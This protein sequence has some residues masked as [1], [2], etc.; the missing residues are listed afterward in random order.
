LETEAMTDIHRE[1]QTTETMCVRPHPA[2]LD[3]ISLA[4]TLARAIADGVFGTSD[5]AV[6][7]Y[8]LSR[9]DDVLRSLDVA[10][11]PNTLHAVAVKANP[12][13]EVLKRLRTAGHGAEVASIGEIELALAAGFPVD[14]IVFD[15][16]V[17]TL[18]ELDTALTLGLRVN[19]NSLSELARIESLYLPLASRSIVGVRINPEVGSGSIAAT[20]VAVPYSKFGVSLRERREALMRA[21]SEYRWLQA[22]HVHIGSQGMSLPQLLDGVGSV[23]EFFLDLSQREGIHRFNIGGGLPAKYRDSDAPPAFDEYALALRQRCPQLFRADVELVTEFGRAIHASCGWVA[24]KVEYVIDHDDGTRTLFLHVGA[25]MFLRKAYRP[26]DWHHDITICDSHGQLR[27]GLMQEA[28]VAGPLC[29]AGDYLARNVLLPTDVR[30]G[31]W[32]VIH[33]AGAYTFSM[34]SMYNSRQFPAIV[35]YEANGHNFQRLRSRQPISDIVTFW[36]GASTP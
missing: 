36:S 32:A 8:D 31:D 12:A 24:S 4:D 30:E 19:A 26:D 35:G 7:F 22:L 5:D 15:S 33:D 2:R 27:T 16:P 13:V 25:D 20:S 28:R 34:W 17:K 10:F 14:K 11:P 23:Y 3:A 9:L 1:A 6:V 29:F 21:F 18:A